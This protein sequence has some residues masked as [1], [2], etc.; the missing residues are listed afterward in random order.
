MNCRKRPVAMAMFL[1]GCLLFLAPAHAA[2]IS[3]GFNNNTYDQN[4]WFPQTQG[5]GPSTTVADNRLEITIPATSSGTPGFGA[6]IG[7][8]FTLVGDFDVQADFTL[9]NWPSPTGVQVG[10]QPTLFSGQFMAGV[11][12][13]NDPSYPQTQDYEAWLNGYDI[14]TP[15]SDSSGKLRLTRTGHTIAASYWTSGGWQLLASQTDPKFGQNCGIQ[16]YAY[17]HNFQGKQVQV[18]FDNL[19]MTA[20]RFG[21]F[22]RTGNPTAAILQLLQ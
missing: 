6:D 1:V 19:Q 16:F 14:K 18:A 11:W 13:M 4:S 12:L 2:T 17:A 8:I 15:T 9:F 3:E 5:Q 10:I 21:T 7:T 20:A 22:D